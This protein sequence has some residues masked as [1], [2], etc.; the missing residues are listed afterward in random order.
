LEKNGSRKGGE[1]NARLADKGEVKGRGRGL[2]W[3]YRRKRMQTWEGG[4]ERDR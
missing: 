2:R 4:V 1:R 3:V